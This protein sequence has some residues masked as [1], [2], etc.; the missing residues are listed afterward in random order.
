MSGEPDAK[1][2]LKDISDFE[3]AKLQHVQ[4]KEKYV[5]PTKDAI[6]QEKTEKQLLDEIE[7]G[8]QLKPTTPVEKNKLPTKADIEAE[9]SAK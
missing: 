9:K 7:K 4:T 5:L 2:V 6:A 3:K 1:A 8:T